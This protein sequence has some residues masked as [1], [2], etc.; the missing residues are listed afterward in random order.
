MNTQ[1]LATE[2]RN[3]GRDVNFETLSLTRKLYTSLHPVAPFPGVTIKRDISYGPDE[4][5]RLDLFLADKQ[6]GSPLAVLIYVHGGGFIGGDKYTPGSPFYDNVGTWAVRNGLAG[7][8]I[9]HRL[10]PRHQWPAVIQDIAAVMRWLRNNAAAHSIDSNRVYLMGQSAGAAHVANY[11]AHP[12]IYTPAPHG[13]AGA[14]FMS[15]LF[16]LLTMTPD[17][18]LQ[19]YFGSDTSRYPERTSLA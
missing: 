3:I 10:A 6:A 11:I 8:N 14:I 1:Q 17:E 5:N 9:T 2:I 18:L 4:R 16:N 12:E 15:G 7:I 19:S 13:V